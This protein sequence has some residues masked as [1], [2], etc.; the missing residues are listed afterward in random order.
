MKT[1]DKILQ[2]MYELVAKHGYDK[3]SIAMICDVIGIKKPS[4]YYYFKSKEEIFLEL[5]DSLDGYRKECDVKELFHKASFMED[6]ISFG[7]KII[8]N[9]ESD[10]ELASV[11]TEFYNQ[12]SRIESV[13]ARMESYDSSTMCQ[14]RKILVY[15]VEIGALPES[16]DVEFNSQYLAFAIDNIEVCYTFG[17]KMRYKEIWETTVRRM[18]LEVRSNY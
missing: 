13:K 14:L 4:V 12:S 3:T 8:D 2:T 6:L 18:F 16:F 11:I 17:F 1:R 15:G 7:N 9:S 10:H 5:I